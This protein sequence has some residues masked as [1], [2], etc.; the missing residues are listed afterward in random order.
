MQKSQYSLEETEVFSKN[1]NSIP[2]WIPGKWKSVFKIEG[3][4]KWALKK[5]F[6]TLRE[7]PLY[8]FLCVA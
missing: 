3:W 8:A 7:K 4:K 5:S 2:V 1:K 6:E